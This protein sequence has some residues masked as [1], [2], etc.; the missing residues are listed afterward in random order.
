MASVSP[1]FY[2]LDIVRSCKN[3]IHPAGSVSAAYDEQSS[4]PEACCR[5]R[6]LSASR[7]RGSSPSPRR[8]PSSCDT[9]RSLSKLPPGIRTRRRSCREC[10]CPSSAGRR[11]APGGAQCRP[12]AT[13]LAP[14]KR[15]ATPAS[16]A[17]RDRRHSPP[18]QG[19]AH[20]GNGCC[21]EHTG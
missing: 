6:I 15:R 5:D 12:C 21:S 17:H 13:R 18:G 9:S 11:T 16:A 7:P 19:H 8:T 3:I 14:P 10:P 20:R 2:C 1:I 4:I